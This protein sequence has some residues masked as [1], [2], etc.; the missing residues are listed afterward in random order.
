MGPC[1]SAPEPNGTQIDISH[2]TILRLIGRGGFAD[3]HVAQK[4]RDRTLFAIKRI[5]K[6]RVLI[7]PKSR[8]RRKR[9]KSDECRRKTGSATAKARQSIEADV[10]KTGRKT[11]EKLPSEPT[12][13]D[14][15]IVIHEGIERQAGTPMRLPKDRTHDSRVSLTSTQ[16]ACNHLKAPDVGV[17]QGEARL[18][19]SRM[20]STRSS[21]VESCA[22]LSAVSDTYLRSERY[23]R[24]GAPLEQT[25]LE[26]TP[27]AESRHLLLSPYHSPD[28]KPGSIQQSNGNKEATGDLSLERHE[29]DEAEPVEPL[30]RPS[31]H[32]KAQPHAQADAS[33]QQAEPARGHERDG[34]TERGSE[35]RQERTHRGGDRHEDGRVHTQE[36]THRDDVQKHREDDGRAVHRGDGGKANEPKH[37]EEKRRS[38]K[39]KKM[40]LSQT[41]WTERD[42]LS[43]VTSP[44]LMRLV[45]A[46]QDDNYLYLVMPYLRGGDLRNLLDIQGGLPD[47][48]V[49]FYM[50]E[51]LLALSALHHLSIVYRDVKPRNL[52]LDRHGHLCLADY[53][54]CKILKEE[55][56]W[57]TTGKA[58]TPGFRAPEVLQGKRYSFEVDFFSLGVTCY[59][60]LSGKHAF[61]S[62]GD[63]FNKPLTL[64]RLSPAASDFVVQLLKMDPAQRLGA[65]KLVAARPTG[66]HT[67]MPPIDECWE[68]VKSHAWFES[69]DWKRAAAQRLKPLHTPKRGRFANAPKKVKPAKEHRNRYLVLTEAHQRLFEGFECQVDPVHRQRR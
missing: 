44:F 54:L 66:A 51:L 6:R 3:V 2:F 42:I 65:R 69:I 60:L 36:R 59:R 35:G 18:H 34:R 12:V 63:A 25:P 43:R 57:M 20:V 62:K 53:G 23:R 11:G 17:L 41:V 8:R 13:D 21:V 55:N 27:E 32:D 30:P 47:K 7:I 40:R 67:T 15:V 39:E 45:W 58:G 16:T 48:L 68:D 19:S 26:Q 29:K 9:T 10:S 38:G 31:H 46:F 56:G 1:A 14:E 4:Y 50:V 28:D 37:A 24:Y 33:E 52:L 64:R 49:R 61:G 5:P 22:T